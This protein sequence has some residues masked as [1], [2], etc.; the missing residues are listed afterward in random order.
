MSKRGWCQHYTGLMGPGMVK[1][2]ECRA[3]VPYAAVTTGKRDDFP[4]I[5]NGGSCPKREPYTAAQLAEQDAAFQRVLDRVR[6]G[7]CHTCGKQIEPSTIVGRCKYGACG[8][9]IGQVARDDDDA[10]P[11]TKE[12]T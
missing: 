9:R 7:L 12:G 5:G 1:H 6:Q 8:H 4:C 2:I 3:G 11:A 10:A